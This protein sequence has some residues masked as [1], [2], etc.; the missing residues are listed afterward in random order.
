MSRPF[1]IGIAGGTKSGKTT[2]ARALKEALG[3]QAALLAMDHYYLDQSHLSLEERRRVNYDH[4]D[5]F[6]LPLY[7]EHVQ[8][9]LRWESV[10]EPVYSFQDYTRT[11]LTRRV[12]PA[13]VLIL[14]GILL[15]YDP[16]LRALLDLKVFVEADADERFIR[17]LRRDLLERGRSLESVVEQYLS[18][19]KPMHEAFVEPTKRYADIVLPRGGENRV[20]LEMLIAKAQSRL[21]ARGGVR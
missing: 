7:L 15:L 3:G 4:P 8:R 12:D 19:V 9:L 5:A 11:P 14:E 21:A 2:V 20:A 13:P 18:Q 10:E 17:R 6:D 16:R 1:A